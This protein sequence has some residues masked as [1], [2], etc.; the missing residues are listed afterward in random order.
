MPKNHGLVDRNRSGQRLLSDSV[1]GKRRAN[2]G[3]AAYSIE[4]NQVAMTCDVV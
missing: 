1:S 4:L 3:S 2:G